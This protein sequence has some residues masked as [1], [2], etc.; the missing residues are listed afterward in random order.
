MSMMA[1]GTFFENY[2]PVVS[3]AF[4]RCCS[5]LAARV[6]ALPLSQSLAALVLCACLLPS[7]ACALPHGPRIV[8]ITCPCLCCAQTKMPHAYVLSLRVSV[9]LRGV[10]SIIGAHS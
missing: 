6:L 7:C 3:P 4:A 9:I 8:F 1:M 2:D 10:Y 5:Q